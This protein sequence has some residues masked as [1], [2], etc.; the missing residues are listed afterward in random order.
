MLIAAGA[1]RHD[2]RDSIVFFSRRQHRPA[3]EAVP[4]QTRAVAPELIEQQV[5]VGHAAR[6]D[7]FDAGLALG[8]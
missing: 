6:D 2:R 5:D 1:H 7:G 4:D 8:R 3:T